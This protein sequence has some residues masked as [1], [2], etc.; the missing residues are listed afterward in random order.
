MISCRFH[1]QM[2]NNM[3][4]L[5]TAL[6]IG[7]RLGCDVKIPSVVNRDSLYQY[8]IEEVAHPKSLEFE[9]MFEH[10]FKYLEDSD[11]H[12]LQF[13]Y[14]APDLQGNFPHIEPP[15]NDATYYHGYF[16]SEKYFSNIASKLR[17][18]YFTPSRDCLAFINKKH[19]ECSFLK[20]SVAVHYRRA[21]DRQHGDFQEYHRD[22]SLEFYTKALQYIRDKTQIE[23]VIVFSD[24]M[25][26]TK[27]NLVPLLE[28][29]DY[30]TLCME[31]NPNYVDLFLMSRCDHFVVGN[32]SFSW[33]GA[34]LNKNDQKI[35]VVPETEWFG[36]KLKHLDLKDLFPDEWVRF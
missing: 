8:N 21:G 29:A 25:S 26:W 28:S 24:D 4:Q 15:V 20:N 7:E 35:V 32:S 2:G 33:W 5:A 17:D 36:P 6:A 22:V 34:W 1:G 30:N 10:E 31:D 9:K 13:V 12:N 3:F 19:G 23:N 27:E 14:H 16:Q 11:N 18:L